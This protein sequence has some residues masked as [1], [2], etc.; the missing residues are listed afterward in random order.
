MTARFSLVRRRCLGVVGL[1]K[2]VT[3]RRWLVLRVARHD[4]EMVLV[5]V[6]KVMIF[7][8]LERKSK[9]VKSL[10]R[11]VRRSLRAFHS[12]MYLSLEHWSHAG[13]II[14]I[15]AIP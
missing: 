6:V 8:T 9:K 12:R 15:G 7:G 13:D 2:G 4:F 14:F 11:S 3:L 5:V 10:E 1:L